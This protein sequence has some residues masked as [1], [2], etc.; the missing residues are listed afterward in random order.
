MNADLARPH[1]ELAASPADA[2]AWPDQDALPPRDPMPP[3]MNSQRIDPFPNDGGKRVAVQQHTYRQEYTSRYTA[4]EPMEPPPT[5]VS[6][7]R[8]PP[9]EDVAAAV[10]EVPSSGPEVPRDAVAVMHLVKMRVLSYDQLS[11]LTYFTGNKTVARRRLRRLHAL[12]WIHIWDRPTGRGAPPRYAYPTRKALAW[13]DAVMRASTDGTALGPLVNLMR[14]ATPRQPWKFEPGVSPL[15]LTHTEEANEALIAW[16]RRSGE[17][18]LWASS[19]DCPFPEHV[20]WRTMPQPDYV[21]VLDRG[22]VPHLVFGEHDRGTEGREVVA[23]KLRVYR[24]WFE[25]PDI[26]ARTIGFR[27]FQLFITVAGERA[28]RRLEHLTQLVRDEGV[29]AFTTL[30]LTGPGPVLPSLT[31]DRMDFTHCSF[32]QSRVPLNAEACPS[33][34]APTHQLAREELTAEASPPLIDYTAENDA[35]AVQ[36]PLPHHP[37]SRLPERSRLPGRA[38]PDGRRPTSRPPMRT[39]H[40]QLPSGTNR[41][42]LP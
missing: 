39:R 32:C 29:E 14:P 20:E 7:G 35:P 24:T 3:D 15:F 27:G 36:P 12:G 25:T 30:A 11:R 38:A 26:L 5:P 42:P 19:W 40:P 17:R 22:G 10:T 6:E 18:V 4:A 37:R 21:L 34:G 23:R 9:P 16:L 28:P 31:H 41:S 33:C 1:D 8:E 13:G 2:E